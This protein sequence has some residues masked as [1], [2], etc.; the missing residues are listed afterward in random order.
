MYKN[1]QSIE[2]L[3]D[4]DDLLRHCFGNL[5]TIR[6][7]KELMVY[8]ILLVL[9]LTTGV[10]LN[11]ILSLRWKD[12]LEL[13]SENDAVVKEEL[14]IR[15]YLIPFHPKTKQLISELY[16]KLGFPNLNSLISD[17]I[18]ESKKMSSQELAELMLRVGKNRAKFFKIEEQLLKEF[19]FE[20]YLQVIFGRKVLETNGYSNKVSKQLKLHFGFKLNQ[21][22]F[23]FL[24]YDSK[25]KIVFNLY[26]INLDCK[27]TLI[28]L[29]DKNFNDTKNKYPF[30][31]FTAF[32]KILISELNYYKPTV[33][34]SIRLLLIISL[35]NGVK[36]STLIRLKWEDI[37]EVDNGEQSIFVKDCI[38]FEGYHITISEWLK[39]K[40]LY[41]FEQIL[42]CSKDNPL[43]DDKNARYS[44][45]GKIKYKSSPNLANSVFVMN[46]G[47]P[48]TQPS[49]SREIK[50]A[51]HQMGFPHA[52]K[53]TSKSTVIMYGRRIIEIKGNHRPT[54][55]KLK[56]HFNFRSTKELFNFL[57]IDLKEEFKFKEKTR[58]TIFDEILY[59]L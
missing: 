22:L 30:Q 38:I 48:I 55:Q 56:E 45:R 16:N 3:I 12:I 8:R 58:G 35:Y 25:E 11:I 32:S 23:D 42:E 18:Y 52:N 9:C 59:D 44:I 6:V 20:K 24:G 15:K 49:L 19:D 13:G 5:D 57:Y 2:K 21:E 37:I 7:F 26:K 41:H 4:F 1:T 39:E 27:T 17:G 53:I 43:E 46:T 54:I 51:L 34:N 47:N 36:P 40:L 50:K 29:H 33:T 10:E 31:K 14:G 28:T